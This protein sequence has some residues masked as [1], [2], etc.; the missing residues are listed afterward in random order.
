MKTLSILM[1]SFLMVLSASAQNRHHQNDDRNSNNNRQYNNG[2][3]NNGQFNN[4]G[5]VTVTLTGNSNEQVYIDGRNYT[6]GNNRN[7]GYNNT[8]QITDLQPGQH[9]LQLNTNK[10]NGILG[11]IFGGRNNTTKVFNVKT[12]YDTQIA[13]NGNGRARI[14]ESRSVTYQDNRNYRRD[15]R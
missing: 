4:T 8:I 13:I 10:N 2:Q 9:T 11:S 5:I 12:G 15:D 1:A 3:Y 6:P 14:S 7:N